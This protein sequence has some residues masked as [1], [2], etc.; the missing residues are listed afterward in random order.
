M[1]VAKQVSQIR[2]PDAPA[3]LDWIT[4]LRAP[5]IKELIE[6]GP[7]QLWLFDD[8]DL[9]EIASP[10]YPGERLIMCRNPLLAAERRRKR[11]ELL[12]A[13]ERSLSRIRQRSSASA[14][15]SAA[16]PRSAWP[17]DPCSTSTRW[18]S[19]SSSSSLTRA[20]STAHRRDDRRRGP[21]RRHLRDPHQR[22]EG[23]ALARGHSRR[24]Q[25]LGPGRA[26]LPLDKDRRS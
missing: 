9:A 23:G 4:A 26:R 7:L 8:R 25:G 16:G 19:T 3:G 11:D 24:L 18:A 5:Q 1:L 21:A 22:A 10:D 12:A 17:W 2:S 20:S 14:R 6:A 13:T 15:R